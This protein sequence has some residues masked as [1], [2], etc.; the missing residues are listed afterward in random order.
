MFTKDEA[1]NNYTHITFENAIKKSTQ[2]SVV[3][4]K[5]RAKYFD[6]LRKKIQVHKESNKHY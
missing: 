3:G 2:I 5:A 6:H 1:F 4:E